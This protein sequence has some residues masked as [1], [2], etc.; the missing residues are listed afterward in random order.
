MRELEGLGILAPVKK[1]E[2]EAEKARID[3]EW[4]WCASPRR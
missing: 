4:L 2:E 1:E 3:I